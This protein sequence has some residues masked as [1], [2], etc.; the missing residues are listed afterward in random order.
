MS[1]ELM[2]DQV[3]SFCRDAD[4]RPKPTV[5]DEDNTASMYRDTTGWTIHRKRAWT[6]LLS[7]CHYDYID[8]SI[9]VGS[10]RGTVASQRAI[11]TWMQH[12]S[13]FMASFDF[14]HAKLAPDWIVSYPQHLTASGLSVQGRDYV[15]YLADSREL[16]DAAA[17]EPIGGSVSLSLPPGTYDVRLYSPVT[18]EYSPAI[19]VAGGDAKPLVLPPFREDVVIRAT[20]REH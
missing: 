14:T 15:A 6:A 3:A 9:T 5:L 19:E 8:F 20:R 1:K 4:T 2:L 7:R 18:G 13:E 16:T 12:L 10:E 17:G 11:R